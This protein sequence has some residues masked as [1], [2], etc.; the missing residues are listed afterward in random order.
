MSKSTIAHFLEAVIAMIA[1]TLCSGRAVADTVYADAVV[2][3]VPGTLPNPTY[4]NP[5]A[6]LGGLNPV[7]GSFGPTTYYLTPFDPAFGPSNLVEIGAGGSL[8]LQLAAPVSTNGDTIGVHTGIGLLDANYPNGTNSNPAS[9]VN[10]WLRQADVLVSANGVDWGNLGTITFSN[11]SNYYTGEAT[12]PE[13]G[14]P[15]VGPLANQGQPFLGSL[16]SFNGE[17]WQQTLATLDGS[18]GGTWLNLSGVTDENG[19]PIAE[20]NYIAFDVPADLPLDPS[21]GNPEIMMVD[22]VVGIA[23]PEPASLIGL[24]LGVPALMAACRRGRRAGSRAQPRANSRL[25][26]DVTA[27]SRIRENSAETA[28]EFSRR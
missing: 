19:N 20:V 17:D 26:T 16:S 25:L 15:G 14:T 28:A 12:D 9:Y 2:S 8:V 5:G 18:A 21:T 11:P 4:N 24:A 7:A 13:G 1:L 3:Y 23:V 22:A 6:A 27:G 10:S